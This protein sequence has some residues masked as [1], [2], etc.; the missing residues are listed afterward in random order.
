M[1]RFLNLVLIFYCIILVLDSS[2]KLE[3]GILVGNLFS[4]GNFDECI[5]V[6]DVQTDLGPFSG[7]HCLAKLTWENDTFMSTRRFIALVSNWPCCIYNATAHL[8]RTS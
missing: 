5:G 6:T 8:R 2:A 1:Y 3:A 7:K 4:I